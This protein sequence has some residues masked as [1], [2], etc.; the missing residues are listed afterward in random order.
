MQIKALSI[1]QPYASAILLGH[2]DRENRTWQTTYRGLL[3]IHA[4][5][6]VMPEGYRDYPDLTPADCPTGVLLG[7]VEVTGCVAAPW[8][9]S[10]LVARPRLLRRPIPMRGA[11]G[12][13][14]VELDESLL[15]S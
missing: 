6:S 14:P 10:I 13:W 2:K 8:G 1:K 15:I 11:L 7:V 3:A 4:P 12:L 5:K 9:Y